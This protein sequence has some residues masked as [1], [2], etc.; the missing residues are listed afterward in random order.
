MDSEHNSRIDGGSELA[1]RKPGSRIIA[2]FTA[3][4]NIVLFDCPEG[5]LAD[6][7]G[8]TLCSE[9]CNNGAY[10][11]A[12]CNAPV[13]EHALDANTGGASWNVTRQQATQ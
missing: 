12:G 11:A 2:A 5:W 1:S 13:G 8:G 10:V 6:R 7:Q 4:P 9:V 3:S